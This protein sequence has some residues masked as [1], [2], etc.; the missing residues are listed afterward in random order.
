LEPIF[1]S[2][3][4]NVAIAIGGRQDGSGAKNKALRAEA[5]R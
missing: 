2:V 4:L 5:H 1:M 3:D